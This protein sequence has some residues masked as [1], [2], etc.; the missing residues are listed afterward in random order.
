MASLVKVKIE[1]EAEVVIPNVNEVVVRI[2]VDPEAEVIIPQSSIKRP[3][4][5]DPKESIIGTKFQRKFNG[6]GIWT[7]TVGE[8]DGEKYTVVYTKQGEKNDEKKHTLLELE[9]YLKNKR[10]LSGSKTSSTIFFCQH[11]HQHHQYH[12]RI[13]IIKILLL[14]F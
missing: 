11:H 1:V 3:R 12:Q 8:F 14:L 7:G 9:R 4:S 5:E 2:K 10:R 13:V 6:Y